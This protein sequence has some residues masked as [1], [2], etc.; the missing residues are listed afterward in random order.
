MSTFL[1][2]VVGVFVISTLSIVFVIAIN[3]FLDSL[4]GDKDG[5]HRKSTKEVRGS[6]AAQSSTADAGAQTLASVHAA[7]KSS[8]AL[9]AYYANQANYAAQQGSSL[10]AFQGA[11]SQYGGLAGVNSLAQAQ[12]LQQAQI[13][14]T[15][16]ASVLSGPSE[17][18]HKDIKSDG[19][20]YGEIIAYRCWPIRNGFLWS[21]A[22]DR[23]WAPNEPM[24]ALEGHLESGLGV[25]AFKEM[26]HVVQHFGSGTVASDGTA[27]GTIELWGEIVE[28][29]I[30]YRAEYAQI[31]S[32]DFVRG[33][34]NLDELRKLYGVP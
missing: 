13:Y 34:A 10:S 2:I 5:L 23:A 18:S 19:V 14:G 9:Q 12:A 21:T 22:A 11:L 31:K 32:I 8:L 27:F 6:T 7:A 1:S 30:G 25:Y 20:R 24:K 28:H 17:P 33:G 29:E 26:S 3:L 16:F 4:D 15:G